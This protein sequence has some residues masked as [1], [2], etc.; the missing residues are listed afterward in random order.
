MSS[1]KR[2]LCAGLACV[3]AVLLLD[4]F[5]TEDEDQRTL[6]QRRS[7]GGNASNTCT[8]L[9]ELGVPCEY[10]GTLAADASVE[11][12]FLEADFR[13]R[14]VPYDKCPRIP[15]YPTPNSVILTN[16]NNYSMTPMKW[17][18]PTEF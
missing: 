7:R 18:M 17:P 3:D 9:A 6:G 5:P 13:R 12:A 16:T 2:V 8:V 15:G 11:S 4:R 14:G 10:F 1:E